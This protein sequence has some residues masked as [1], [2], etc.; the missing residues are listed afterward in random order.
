MQT[1]A[2]ILFLNAKILL[3]KKYENSDFEKNFTCSN[4]QL[5]ANENKYKYTCKY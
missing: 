2:K 5:L 1:N 3:L 4:K